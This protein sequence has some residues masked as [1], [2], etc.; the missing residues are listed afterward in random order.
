[1]N[2][3]QF[4]TLHLVV[5]QKH[6]GPDHETLHLQQSI[7]SNHTVH[8]ISHIICFLSQKLFWKLHGYE[9]NI[10]AQYRANIDEVLMRKR[11]W[12][13]RNNSGHVTNM[14]CFDGRRKRTKIFSIKMYTIFNVSFSGFLM[15]KML[16]IFFFF[17]SFFVVIL[18]L[19]NS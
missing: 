8:T 1:M 12:P 10:K 13:T 2:T 3:K 18:N 5:W 11:V 17:F 14:F 16:P 6:F 9:S 15:D 19:Q 4:I 7:P